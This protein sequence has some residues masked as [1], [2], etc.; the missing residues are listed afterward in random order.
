[1]NSPKGFMIYSDDWAGF[2]EDF[3]DEEMGAIFKALLI[4]F[5]SGEYTEFEDRGMKLFYKNAIRSIELDRGRY[6]EKCSRNAYNIYRRWC[7]E[8]NEAPLEYEEWYTTVYD[9]TR[10]NTKHTNTN[11]N[12]NTNSN[13]NTNTNANANAN[14]NPKKKKKFI[15]PSLDEVKEY[16]SERK[17]SVDPEKFYQYYEAGSWH[18][19]DGNPV[20]NWKQKMISWER[21]KDGKP[22]NTNRSDEDKRS[23]DLGS[24]R[25]MEL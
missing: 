22:D 25:I 3:T 2:I 15:P 4:Y 11:T 10:P 19:K 8:R 21:G 23:G 5:S 20:K 6:E 14:P 12:T 1:M 17:S 9:R 7:K 16:A 13:P 24:I 18:D